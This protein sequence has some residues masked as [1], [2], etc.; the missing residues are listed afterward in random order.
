MCW[1]ARAFFFFLSVTKILLDEGKC[2]IIWVYLFGGHLKN[3]N[4][5][6]L[7]HHYN[8]YRAEDA[9]MRIVFFYL[10]KMDNHANQRLYEYCEAHTTPPTA[11]LRAVER[12]T[13]LQTMAANMLSGH[14]Q[15]QW[16]ALMSQLVRPRR[17]LEIGTFTGYSA[18]CLAQGL[19]ADGVL[20]T[21]ELDE[22]KEQIILKNI[23]KANLKQKIQLHIG[24]AQHIIPSL[25]DTFDLVFIDADKEN[26]GL[27]YDLIF[28]KWRTGGLLIADNVLWK[29]KVLDEQKDRKTTVLDAFNKKIQA[30]VRVENLLLPL[31]DGLMMA[32][33]I[34]DRH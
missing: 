26:Y 14:L 5:F 33:K 20:H 21:L 10:C 24:D 23:E 4:I 17:V 18:I 32:R 31:R 11:A 1:V 15:G 19:T 9:A 8:E 27:Y 6:A 13:H 28:E 2:L 3:I 30:D 12:D 25:N 22:E 16:L 29:G 34:S 7:T